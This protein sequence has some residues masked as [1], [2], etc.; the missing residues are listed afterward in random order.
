MS[1]ETEEQAKADLAGLDVRERVF[2]RIVLRQKNGLE[3]DI[4]LLLKEL[5]APLGKPRLRC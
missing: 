4:D 2:K 5:N 1:S 3:E